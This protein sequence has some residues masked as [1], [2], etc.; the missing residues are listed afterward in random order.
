[1]FKLASL[2][3]AFLLPVSAFIAPLG[4]DPLF[5]E[6]RSLI[7]Q[8]KLDEAKV[9]VT[10]SLSSNPY[11]AEGYQLMYT[12]AKREASAEEQFRWGKW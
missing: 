9:S 2:L 7:S 3:L 12:I 4:E 10:S 8:G 6:G 5:D 11:S 1:M